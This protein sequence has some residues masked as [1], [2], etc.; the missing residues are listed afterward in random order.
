MPSVGVNT[1]FAA[2]TSALGVSVDP[3][4]AFNFLIEIEGILV[5]GF[6]ECSGLQVETEYF[7][8]REGGM[9]EYVHR[10]IG[11]TRYQP[12][13]L[14]HGLTFLIDGLW[15]WHQEV[16][17]GIDTGNFKRR[18][19]TIYLLNKEKIQMKSWNFKDAFPYKWTGPEL[20]ADSGNV[21]FESVELAHRGLR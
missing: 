18:N 8:Y 5:G 14:K 10:F 19:G 15:K 21:A 13:I 17:Q 20:R 6:S 3:F 16:T 9:N 12:I 1:A 7:D 2:G 11:P 4:Q